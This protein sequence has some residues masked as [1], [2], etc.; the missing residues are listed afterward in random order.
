[1]NEFSHF[2]LKIDAKPTMFHGK[3]VRS[4]L[5]QSLWLKKIRTQILIEN[6]YSCVICKH[7]PNEEIIKNYMCMK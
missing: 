2:K 6:N 7:H 3:T 5:T 1:M 4:N